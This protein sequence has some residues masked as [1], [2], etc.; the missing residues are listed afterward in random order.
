[1]AKRARDL[2]AQPPSKRR[3]HGDDETATAAG[4]QEQVKAYMVSALR[5]AQLTPQFHA[6]KLL[7][8]ALKK[9]QATEAQKLT[10]K[11][12]QSV[13]RPS[14]CAPAT[15]TARTGRS[16]TEQLMRRTSK[17]SSLLSRCAAPPRCARSH[18]QAVSVD[19]IPLHLLTT[20]LSKLI[21]LHPILPAVLAALPPSSPLPDLAS[22]SAEGK[23]RNRILANKLVKE[24]LDEVVRA[25]AKR[26]GQEVADRPVVVVPDVKKVPVG[27]VVVVEATEPSK[28]FEQL[29]K[30]AQRT[31]IGVAKRAGLP[32]PVATKRAKR[33][34]SESEV[35]ED[36]EVEIIA[37]DSEQEPEDGFVSGS[38]EGEGDDD[39]EVMRE[40]ARLGGGSGSDEEDDPSDF[41]EGSDAED[42][43]EDS[44]SNL[45]LPHVFA[46]PRAPKERES[47]VAVV[48]PVKPV[49]VKAAKSVRSD[50]PITSSA[51]LPSLAGGYIS[52]SDSDGEDAKWVKAA[53]K[54]DEDKKE[55]KNRR[56]QRARQAYVLISLRV[57][58]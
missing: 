39:D 36:E 58:S 5:P 53:E 44:A 22:A 23:G 54:G 7:L 51:F 19:P 33:P 25:V 1:M 26:M 45:S 21:Y 41:F 46:V 15:H 56:G 24:A 12:K 3:R 47:K 43:V 55:R 28:P 37:S 32:I 35:D 49:K 6:P 20:R 13:L 52:Y 2:A 34:V 31:A 42:D 29:S 27:K 16:R 30:R 14:T 4:Q 57:G 50:K 17:R 18:P 9:A 38:E 8:K 11:L 48:K 40:L 10:R